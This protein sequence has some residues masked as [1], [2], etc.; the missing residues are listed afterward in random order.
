MA[1]LP[2]KADSGWVVCLFKCICVYCVMQ[3]FFCPAVGQTPWVTSCPHWAK[4]GPTR[5]LHGST[6]KSACES[7]FLICNHKKILKLNHLVLSLVYKWNLAAHLS[8][9]TVW[10]HRNG[11]KF[12]Y[13]SAR[14]IGMADMTRGYLHW[15]NERGTMLPIGPVLL[16]PSS[17]FS[18]LHRSGT[19]AQYEMLL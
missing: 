11:Y 9:S 19:H 13:C 6:T 14:A 1:P 4:T 16:S 3:L 17:L 8:T 5:A 15:V 12:M 10:C 18:A 2:G 7:Y